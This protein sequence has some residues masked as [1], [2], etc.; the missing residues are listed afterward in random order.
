MVRSP[1]SWR[2]TIAIT[3]IYMIFY[4]ILNPSIQ[5]L[6]VFV[7]VYVS[8]YL[9]IVIKRFRTDWFVRLTKL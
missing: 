3:T 1:R 5:F 9:I 8:F 2:W 6:S 7:F 4:D